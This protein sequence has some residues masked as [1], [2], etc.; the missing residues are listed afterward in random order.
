MQIIGEKRE[1]M[2]ALNIVIRTVPKRASM[3]I[4]ECI[5]I[6]ADSSSVAFMANNSES[7]VI[8][9]VE[10]RVV[11][12]GSVAVDGNKLYTIISK[13]PNDNIKITTG[14]DFTTKITCNKTKFEIPGQDTEL[15]PNM[16]EADTKSSIDIKEADLKYMIETTAFSAST[17]DS[18]TGTKNMEGEFFQAKDGSLTVTAT[19][20]HR[21]ARRSTNVE[22]DVNSSAIIPITSV[23][24]FGKSLS[25]DQDKMVTIGFASNAVVFDC[26]DMTYVARIYGND[27]Y[28]MDKL[29]KV[30]PT[31]CMTANRKALLECIE[32]TGLLIS[33]SDRKP[34]ILDMSKN[35]ASFSCATNYG[36]SNE[37]LDIAQDGD[38]IRIG[39][40]HRFMI[41][42]LSNIDTEDVSVNFISPK[43]PMTVV[44]ENG[45]YAY[46][47]L[48]V[49]IA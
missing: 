48:P 4:L 3:Q 11:E 22:G 26:E 12:P 17:P 36:I 30:E 46:A 35:T 31:C 8:I 16:I 18:K 19:D 9:N 49:N 25:F 23:V 40:N 39:M 1:L 45:M 41:D 10:A 37:S 42:M 2:R 43:S 34:I 7:S 47:V 27:F 44:G 5:V 32:R 38:D 6:D 21:V 29:F 28:D 13:M 14:D 20:G 15:F 33:A 24:N